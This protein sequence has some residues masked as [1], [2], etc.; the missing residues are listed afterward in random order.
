MTLSIAL[1]GDTAHSPGNTLPALRSAWRAGADLVKVDVHLSSDGYPVLADERVTAAPG[2]VPRP[3]A[4]LTLAELAAVRDDVDRRVPTLME[5]LGEF[6]PGTV[7]PLLIDAAAPDAALAADALLRERG[8]ADR[9]PFTGSAE[10]L[11]A[12]RSRSAET[13]L[14]LPWDQPGLPPEEVARSLRPSCL[15][16]RHTL[17]NRERIGEIHRFGYRVAAWNVNEFP[18]MARH[19]GM[20]VDVIST[21]RIE[22]LTALTK[23]AERGGR[24]TAGS[25]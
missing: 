11:A 13:P 6:R 18:E 23:D 4:D 12:L 7:P 9:V 25:P 5:V 10:A 8:L 17:L 14:L 22:D 21:E 20:G 24:Q 15:A 3:V 16:V 2:G 1:S 19:M